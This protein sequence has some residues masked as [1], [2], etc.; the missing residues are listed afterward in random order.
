VW[1]AYFVVRQPPRQRHWSANT[2]IHLSRHRKPIF[3]AE[4]ALRPGDGERSKDR[5]NQ[6]KAMRRFARNSFK[7]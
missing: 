2:A 4:N 6:A 5:R 7:C 1:K 3:F